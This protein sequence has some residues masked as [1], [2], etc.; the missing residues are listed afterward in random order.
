[1]LAHGEEVCVRF[2]CLTALTALIRSGQ[3]L[4]SRLKQDPGSL[5]I[6]IGTSPGNA[7]HVALLQAIRPAGI[8]SRN[9][10][11]VVFKS[12][13]ESLTALL[14]GHVDVA[15][16]GL[17]NLVKHA[18]A[19]TVRL[20]A[21]TAPTR[22]PGILAGVPTWREQGA[23]VTVSGFRGALGPAKMPPAQIAFWEDAIGK[24]VDSAEWEQV[25][26]KEYAM[27]TRMSAAENRAF[28]DQEY[29][30][31]QA[32]LTELGMAKMK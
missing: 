4:L 28:L 31:Y 24:L 19:G 15:V 25:L 10:K 27:R 22:V 11:T 7:S 32:V 29:K 21:L 3:D 17:S 23:D 26:V 6:S 14:G 9:L 12:N 13:G 5:S 20:I 18:E 30:K 2:L 1:M 8:E 16:S